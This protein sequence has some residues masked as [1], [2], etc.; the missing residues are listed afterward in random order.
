[1][2]WR[3]TRGKWEGGLGVQLTRSGRIGCSSD[4]WLGGGGERVQLT[5]GGGKG[6]G[7]IRFSLLL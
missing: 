5:K 2:G 3:L 1:M 6:V 4:E 7:V